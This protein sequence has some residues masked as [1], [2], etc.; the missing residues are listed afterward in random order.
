MAKDNAL[1]LLV[2]EDSMN[3]VELLVSS[4]KNAGMAV[5]SLSAENEEELLEEYPELEPEDI[6][7]ALLYASEL[8]G[9]E[10]VFPIKTAV[11]M[12]PRATST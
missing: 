3:D 7:A 2:I 10:Q 1:Q 6:R 8:V 11:L 5:R 4:L 9:E 12:A